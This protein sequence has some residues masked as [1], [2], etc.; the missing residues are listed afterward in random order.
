[1]LG[2]LVCCDLLSTQS[3]HLREEKAYFS[4]SLEELSF[5]LVGNHG[6]RSAGQ[7]LIVCPPQSEFKKLNDSVQ[8]AFP[9]E[10]SLVL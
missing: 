7:L 6:I 3:K 5:I 8:S 4:S 2:F 1:M 9:F 10:V